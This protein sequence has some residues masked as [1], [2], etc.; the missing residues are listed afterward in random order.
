MSDSESD[1]DMTEIRRRASHMEAI[2][3][4]EEGKKDQIAQSWNKEQE[5]ILKIWAEKAAGYRW[6]HEHSA[7]HYRRLNNRF[8]YPQ[9]LLSTLAGMG[10]VGITSAE[11][12]N[13][14]YLFGYGI[15][16]LNILTALLTSVQKF[17]MAA[18]KSEI[19]ATVGRQFAAFYRNIMLELS[20]NPRDRTDCLE[21]CKI[22]R[23]EYDRLMNVAP[24][25]PQKIINQFKQKFKDVTY[26]PDIANGLSDMQIWEKSQDTKLEEAFI[27]LRTFYKFFHLTYKKK[28][29]RDSDKKN[30][31]V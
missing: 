13:N 27:K 24:S 29:K 10:G 6:L 8:V 2:A 9:I 19:H 14:Q 7:R 3:M 11:T 25:V 28:K 23:N 4:V 18:E 17:I 1:L 16:V 12:T 30:L 15:A 31:P 20:L 26:K 21:L 5:Q 22:S